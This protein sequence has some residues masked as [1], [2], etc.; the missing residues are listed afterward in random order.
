[1]EQTMIDHVEKLK[2]LIPV[3]QALQEDGQSILSTTTSDCTAIPVYVHIVR[4]T[5]NTFFRGRVA[6]VKRVLE[7]DEWAFDIDGARVFWL[8]PIKDTPEVRTV[9]L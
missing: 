1:M 4:P 2:A 3:V 7:R 6:T 8:E 5:N 9:T